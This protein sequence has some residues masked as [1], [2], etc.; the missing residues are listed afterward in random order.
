MGLKDKKLELTAGVFDKVA[1]VLPEHGEF[2]LHIEGLIQRKDREGL[3][4][5][6]CFAPEFISPEIIETLIL[7]R[8]SVSGRS[9]SG[10]S[11]AESGAESGA[12]SAQDAF[13]SSSIF[14]QS[15]SSLPAFSPGALSPGALSPGALSPENGG[16]HSVLLSSGIRSTGG[17]VLSPSSFAF[18]PAALAGPGSTVQ[19]F[20]VAGPDFGSD[21]GSDPDAL[22]LAGLEMG[23]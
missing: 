16:A 10:D 9:D 5:I 2:K 12:E 11:L 18:G 6:H 15:S 13:S 21:S 1:H 4:F 7:S 17:L 8:S 19:G 23:F 14:S 3:E 22:D 20:Q